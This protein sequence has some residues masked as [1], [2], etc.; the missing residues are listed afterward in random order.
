V[1]TT[2]RGVLRSGAHAIGTVDDD[3]DVAAF[4][5]R[6]YRANWTWLEVRTANGE[7]VGGIDDHPEKPG[8]R[9]YWSVSQT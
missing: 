3:E 1:T 4:V 7:I 6:K 8:R 5:Q 9:I 2:Y